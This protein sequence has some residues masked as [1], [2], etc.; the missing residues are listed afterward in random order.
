MKSLLKNLSRRIALHANMQRDRQALYGMEDYLLKDMG[1]S[2]SQI[3]HY[4][5]K[6]DV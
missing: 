1:I 4:V 3:D 6:S 5:S 2:R